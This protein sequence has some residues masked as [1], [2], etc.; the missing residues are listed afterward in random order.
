MSKNG[1]Q[2]KAT[3]LTAREQEP[4]SYNHKE[5]NPA[6]NVNEP[7]R[8]PVLYIGTHPSLCLDFILIRL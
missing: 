1:G 8:G 7:G 5:V 2:L 3:W 4:Q 6:N